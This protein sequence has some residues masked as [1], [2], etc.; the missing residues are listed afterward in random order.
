MC[1]MW[2]KKQLSVRV[3]LARDFSLRIKKQSIGRDSEVA[4]NMMEGGKS[5]DSFVDF[6]RLFYLYG[7]T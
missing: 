1:S 4:C 5:R 7:K 2:P 3:I 6:I